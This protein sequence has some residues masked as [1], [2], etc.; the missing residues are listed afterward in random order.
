MVRLVTLSGP[1]GVGKTRLALALAAALQDAFADGV[2]F[3]GL[4]SIRAPDLVLAAIAQ[5]LGVKENGGQPLIETLKIFLHEKQ[6]LLVLDNFEQVEA[7]APLIA[8]LLASAPRLKA[9]VTSRALL[10]LSG[11][12]EFAVSPLAVPDLRRLPTADA[13]AQYAAVELFVQRVQAMKPSFALTAANAHAVAE[14]CARLD[15]LPLAI[16]LAA[17]RS[18]LF[19]PAALLARLRPRLTILT[20]GPRDV[21]L[22]HQTLRN[23]ID[24]SYDLLAH[25]EQILFTR[26]GVFVGGCT[27]EAAEAVCN[28]DNHLAA[29]VL[30]LIT[31]LLNKSLLRQEDQQDGE[32]R[33]TMLE[34]IREYALERL[35]ASGSGETL[36]QAYAVYYLALAE[37]AAP[38]LTGACQEEWLERLRRE[39]DNVRAV[40]GWSLDTQHVEIAARIGGALWR[41]WFVCGYWS[42]GRQ[43]LA[44]VLT[45]RAELPASVQATALHGAGTLALYQSD[46]HQATALLEAG[47][48]IQRA[49]EDQGGVSTSLIYLGAIFLDQ[50]DYDH[51]RVYN[52]ECL[53]IRRAL[54]DRRGVATALNNL[55]NVALSQ[56]DFAKAQ[57]LYS[58]SL[59][60]CRAVGDKVE[61]A[62]AINNLGLTAYYQGDHEQ[63]MTLYRQSLDLFQ[64]VGDQSGEANGLC[65]MGAV[66]TAQGDLAPATAYLA[67]SLQLY[68]MLNSPRGVAECFELL[69]GVAAAQ[70]QATRTARL[71]GAAEALRELIAAPLSAVERMGCEQAVSTTRAQIDPATYAAAWAEGRALTLEQAIAYAL[72]E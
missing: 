33:F 10:H 58:E 63:A 28:A 1:G 56:N 15:G 61:I 12:H 29:H 44:S 4:A 21:P 66:A 26:L 70:S 5:V 55:G 49:L 57:E 20:G 16:E 35:A 71:L 43:W 45:Y 18:K 39:H 23:T 60:L 11:E 22:R 54:G 2:W 46:Y 59:A 17:A 34:T 14:I 64:K 52:E 51:A 37:R 67:R 19:A 7:A 3:V 65:N 62:N 69:A 53:E 6:S 48:E 47:L 40:L 36:R 50:G 24:W 30:D 72:Q 38:E 42:E 27:L 32:P 68:R 41:F 25:D 9:L 8:A 13:L 31:S